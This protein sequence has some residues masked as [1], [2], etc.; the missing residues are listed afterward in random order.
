MARRWNYMRCLPTLLLAAMAVVPAAT[1]HAQDESAATVLVQVNQVSV[2]DSSGYVKPLSVGDRLRQHETVIT[3]P[4][5]YARFQLSD[6]SIFE[7]YS[8]SKVVFRETPGLTDLLDLFIGRVKVFIEHSK[9]PNPKDVKTPTAVISVRGTVFDVAVQDADGTTF[10]TLD[11]GVVDVR[12]LTAPGPSV[13]LKPGDSILV[14]PN[15]PLMPQQIS[16]HA[17]MRFVLKA[18]EQAVAQVLFGGRGG[19]GAGSV[20]VG[21]QGDK[22]RPG[23]STGT[24]TG[25]GSGGPS[26]PAPSH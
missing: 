2:L 15:K 20:G 10:V 24:S 3:G 9:G 13:L 26:A 17:A 11:D 5:G 22:G 19:F 8:N 7:V 18:A 14:E 1:L 16:Q 12:N 4:D 6:G 21:P 23:G 25:T